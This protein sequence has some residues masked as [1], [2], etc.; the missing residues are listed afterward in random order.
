MLSGVLA[1]FAK[2]MAIATMV[3]DA[4]VATGGQTSTA[5]PLFGYGPISGR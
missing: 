2:G 4:A 5:G 3:V 1:S